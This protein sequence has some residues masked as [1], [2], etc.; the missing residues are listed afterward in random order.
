MKALL[1]KYLLLIII[2][3]ALS[4]S[5]HIVIAMTPGLLQAYSQFDPNLHLMSSLNYVFNIVIAI[6]LF[7]DMRKQNDVSYPVLILT[8]ISGYIGI[9]VY[10]LL[11][12]KP[13]KTNLA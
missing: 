4:Y 12:V 10:F 1:T 7:L 13:S 9:I 6:C 8:A 2:F 3:S 5:I 11:N